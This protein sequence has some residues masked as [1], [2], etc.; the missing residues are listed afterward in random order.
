[1]IY[2]SYSNENVLVCKSLDSALKKLELAPYV[3]Q[4]ENVWIIGGASV[5]K[6]II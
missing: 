3:E 4:I 6:V 5:Y 2:F 1:M